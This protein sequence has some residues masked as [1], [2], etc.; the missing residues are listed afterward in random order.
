MKTIILFCFIVIAAVGC[1]NKLSDRDKDY[2]KAVIG[3]HETTV[4]LKYRLDSVSHRLTVKDL[5]LPYTLHNDPDLTYD[6][7][8]DYCKEKN[9]DPVAAAKVLAN[10]EK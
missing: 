6:K 7:F 4:G 10:E 9:I 5:H 1:S 2:I 8:M 3:N